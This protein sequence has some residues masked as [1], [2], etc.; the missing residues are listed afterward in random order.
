MAERRH[1]GNMFH[2]NQSLLLESSWTAGMVSILNA[3][4][5]FICG[6]IIFASGQFA[7]LLICVVSTWIMA[8]LLFK[9]FSKSSSLN[10]F[11]GGF[12][13]HHSGSS[14]SYL[15]SDVESFSIAKGLFSHSVVF[16][17]SKSGTGRVKSSAFGSFLGL[18]IAHR[19]S[20]GLRRLPDNYGLGA[21]GLREL[22]DQWQRK[23]SN[24][25]DAREH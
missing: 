7:G 16:S 1:I 11:Q 12:T 21:E 8:V 19:T 10:L 2:N 17:L 3:L 14:T 4:A 15:W 20:E 6:A 25:R 13:L 5:C 18:R 23:F 22:M 9:K 24:K